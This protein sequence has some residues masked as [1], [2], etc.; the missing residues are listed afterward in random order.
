MQAAGRQLGVGRGRCDL[1]DARWPRCVGPRFETT[2]D[3]SAVR[4]AIQAR[5]PG[6]GSQAQASPTQIQDFDEFPKPHHPC[7]PPNCRKKGG[8]LPG[9]TPPHRRQQSAAGGKILTARSKE[10]RAPLTPR[11]ST[12]ERRPGTPAGIPTDR[13]PG[14]GLPSGRDSAARP[15]ALH[16]GDGH[17]AYDT[18]AVRKQIED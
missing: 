15:G 12:P 16:P 14:R 4:L 9:S 8:P 5:L 2:R 18:N 13:R 17:R 11:R 10:F 7:S 6:D 1:A 3:L